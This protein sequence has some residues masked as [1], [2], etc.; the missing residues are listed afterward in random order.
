MPKID[1]IRLDLLTAGIE[2]KRVQPTE[3]NV[4]FKDFPAFSAKNRGLVTLLF[5]EL[6][7]TAHDLSCI[8]D[9]NSGVEAL[10]IA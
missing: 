3:N 7:S 5:M 8:A 6:E 1:E 4:I 10:V 2:G 9:L